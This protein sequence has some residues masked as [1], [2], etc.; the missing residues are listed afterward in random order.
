MLESVEFR[1]NHKRRD[2]P[3]SHRDPIVIWMAMWSI[4]DPHTGG[5]TRGFGSSAR[6]NDE[7]LRRMHNFPTRPPLSPFHNRKKSCASCAVRRAS[8]PAPPLIIVTAK[9]WAGALWGLLCMTAQTNWH[10]EHESYR[11]APLETRANRHPCS[12]PHNDD[13]ANGTLWRG[14]GPGERVWGGCHYHKKSFSRGSVTDKHSEEHI[15][16]S[17]TDL[18]IFITCTGTNTNRGAK[19]RY[20][21]APTFSFQPHT[22]I[23]TMCLYLGVVKRPLSPNNLFRLNVVTSIYYSI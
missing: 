23:S 14:T 17:D 12:L 16:A 20:G 5:W 18:D 1:R 19:Y 6:W 10:A 8:A 13:S 2:F 4:S 22:F 11:G 21:H 15:S 3:F 9:K 7:Q